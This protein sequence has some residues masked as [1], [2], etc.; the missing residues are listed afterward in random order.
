MNVFNIYIGTYFHL[1]INQ[2]IQLIDFCMLMTPCGTMEIPIISFRKD[3]F[4]KHAVG[5]FLKPFICTVKC[6]SHISYQRFSCAA[7]QA[8]VVLPVGKG[9]STPRSQ[10][11]HMWRRHGAAET[12][13][14]AGHHWGGNRLLES[15]RCCPELLPPR[16]LGGRHHSESPCSDQ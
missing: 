5:F 14:A 4:Y 2:P 11:D 16:L 8:G 6:F 10:S 7:S 3:G 13:P 1:N 9:C 15:S 12:G